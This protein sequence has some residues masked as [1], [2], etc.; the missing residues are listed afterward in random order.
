MS[1]LTISPKVILGENIKS[2][3]APVEEGQVVIHINFYSCYASCARSKGC[4]FSVS[5]Q[6]YLVPTN[7][8]MNSALVCAVNIQTSDSISI[9]KTMTRFALIFEALPESAT[10]FDFI[11]PGF[12]GWK[13]LNI[14]RNQT[15]VYTLKIQGEKIVLIS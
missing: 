14:H 2:L 11:E 4:S 12:R 3:I 8:L 1:F 15:D 9:K 7:H 13:C 5:P 10:G 6:I